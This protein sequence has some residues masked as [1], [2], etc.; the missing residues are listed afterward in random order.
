MVADKSWPC[1]IRQCF[2]NSTQH[3]SNQSLPSNVTSMEATAIV[4]EYEV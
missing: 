4:D 2:V 1:S 3:F